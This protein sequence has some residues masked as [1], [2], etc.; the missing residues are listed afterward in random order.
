MLQM[1]RDILVVSLDS[2]PDRKLLLLHFHNCPIYPRLRELRDPL[3]ILR[4]DR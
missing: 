2:V 1:L 3:E 4:P